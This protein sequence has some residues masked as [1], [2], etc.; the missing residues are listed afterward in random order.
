MEEQ[1]NYK[2][3]LIPYALAAFLIGLVGGFSSVLGPAFVLDLGIDYNNTTWTALAQAMSTAACAPILGKLGDM[4]GRKKTLLLGIAVFTLGNA[5]SALANSLMVMLVARFIVGVGTAAMAPV[6]LAYIIAAFPKDKMAKGFSLYM[7]I[8]SG[9]VIFGPTLGA[10]VVANYGWRVMLWIC[11][12]I[13]AGVFAVCLF[14]AGGDRSRGQRIQNFDIWGAILVL[15]FFSL[16]LC[17]PAFGQNFGW[18]SLPFI[19]VLIGAVISL[20]GLIIAEKR[21]VQPI[22]PGAFMK[23]KRF[24]LSVLALFLTQGL[25]QANMTNTIVFVNYTQPDNS[26]FSGY[27]IS[28]MYLG[29]ALGA[30]C[31]GPL[32][33]RFEPKF[34]LTG[35]LI[36]TGIGCGAL[37]LFSAGV[38]V[39]VLMAALGL[40]GLGL[41]GNGTILL[42]VALSGLPQEKAGAGTGTYGLFRDLAAPFGVAVFVPFFTNQITTQIGRGISPSAAAVGAMHMLGLAELACVAAGIVTILLLPGVRRKADG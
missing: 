18:S 8:S 32:A 5:L 36:L 41:G 21:A 33:D 39:F 3:G 27:A 1:A 17:I 22:L 20:G 12:A 38:S 2:K 4:I 7:L 31:I 25:M 30:A 34:V 35:S 13:C 10:L 37:Y 26:A 42:K 9:S 11:A 16:V 28:V 24:I 23:R 29:M 6:I 19:A 15:I 40:L 14:T